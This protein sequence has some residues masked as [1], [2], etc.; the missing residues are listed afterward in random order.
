MEVLREKMFT[1]PEFTY[2]HT[3]SLNNYC[4]RLW[5]SMPKATADLFAL[6]MSDK[7]KIDF[8]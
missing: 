3:F 7:K 1:L 4:F 6:K 8:L 5:G 2:T